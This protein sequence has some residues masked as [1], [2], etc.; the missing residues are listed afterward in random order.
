MKKIKFEITTPEKKV[1]SAEVDQATIPT[2][3]GEITVLPDHIPLVS[4]LVPGELR[5][6]VNGEEVLM[7]VAGGFIEVLPNKIVILADA[8]ERAED[9][10]EK[11]AEEAHRRATELLA[12]KRLDAE[13]FAS[14]SAQMERELAR[15]KVARKRKY[16]DLPQARS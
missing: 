3:Q 9:I 12:E 4:A 13:E 6:I 14:L 11:Q 16:R 15:L 10:D 7:A 5:L 1:F 8:A 2:K